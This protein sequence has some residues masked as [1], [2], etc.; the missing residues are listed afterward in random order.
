MIEFSFKLYVAGESMRSRQATVNIRR[1]ADEKL[2]GRYE[3]TVID[4]VKDPEAAE[5]DR[6]LTTPT[7][8]KERPAPPRRVTGDLSDATLVLA[9]LAL[10]EL[11][12]TL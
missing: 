11:E 9:A 3:L 2:A 8:V 12:E 1:L 4:V 7:L 5:A 10:D 6:I